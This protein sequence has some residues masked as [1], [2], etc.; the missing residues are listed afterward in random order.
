[1][2]EEDKTNEDNLNVEN[3]E[4]VRHYTAVSNNFRLDWNMLLYKVAQ[5]DGYELDWNKL[6][7]NEEQLEEFNKQQKE[8]YV[9]SDFFDYLTKPV[10]ERSAIE[11]FFLEQSGFTFDDDV[12]ETDDQY[13]RLVYKGDSTKEGK[14]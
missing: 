14:Q 6:V 3:A 2:S 4:P 7:Y 8:K 1:M 11:K 9:R 12:D 10:S 13:D 5:D